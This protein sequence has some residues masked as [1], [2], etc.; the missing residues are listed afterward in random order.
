VNSA[1]RRAEALT[2]CEIPARPG[3]CCSMCGQ[4]AGRPA[5]GANLGKKARGATSPPA[6]AIAPAFP[7]PV[8]VKS[9][10]KH[11]RP[12]NP[13]RAAE[14]LERNFG[15]LAVLVRA[16]PCCVARCRRHPSDPAHV[17]GRG[18]GGHAWVEVE[19]V[20]VGNL[21]PLCRWHHDESGRRGADTFDG[22]TSFALRL[23][24][25]GRQTAPTLGAVAVA[26][27][28]WALER[29]PMGAE[30]ELRW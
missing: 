16:L 11:P 22:A 9:A 10:R 21:A 27:G 8:T 6:L 14:R 25:L 3:V 17:L 13:E 2:C 29:G 20:K 23:P 24:G 15:W 19:G 5:R 7:K 4:V 30:E 1:R 26:V 12:Q 28:I 18:A